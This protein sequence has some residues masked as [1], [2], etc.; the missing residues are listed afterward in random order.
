METLTQLPRERDGRGRFVRQ[1]SRFREMVLE[2]PPSGKFHLYVSLACPWASRAVIVRR[3]KRLE[4][5]VGMTVLDPLRDARGWRFREEAPD[6]V[7]GF[8]FLVGAYLATDPSFDQRVTVPVLWDIAQGRIVNNES[9]D[10]IRM[11]NAWSDDGPD[12]YPPDL[13][14]EIDR[15]ND[16]VYRNLNNG[17]Y[18]AGFAG[19]QE[20][21]EEAFDDVFDTL[22][23]LD[24]RLAGRRYLTAIASPRRT[25]ASSRP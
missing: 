16:R 7:N 15:V 5:T 1:E 14:P 22:A 3:L 19:S 25:S 23:W 17:V 9:A 21:Y 6:P 18:R 12:L 13:Q 20:A 8:T 2:P 11:F 10:V 4:K 24:R